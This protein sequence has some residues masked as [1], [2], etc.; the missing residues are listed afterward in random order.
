MEN[1][2]KILGLSLIN[3]VYKTVQTSTTC[4]LQSS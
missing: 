1:I 4:D 3:R 2:K